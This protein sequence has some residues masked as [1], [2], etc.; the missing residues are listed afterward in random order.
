MPDAPAPV[1][2]DQEE[3]LRYGAFARR[4]A[5]AARAQ[6]LPGFDRGIAATGKPM[7]DG[8]FDPVTR[9]DRGA[10]TAIRALIESHFPDHGIHGEEY[11]VKQTGNPLC[12]VLDPIDGTR[13]YISALA[14]WGTLIA[15]CKNGRPV[16]GLMD[17]PVVN[18]CFTGFGDQALLC[19]NENERQVHVRSCPSLSQATLSTTDPYLFAPG[20]ERTAFETLRVATRLQRYG[21]D[22]T[23]YG[24]LARGS[25]DLVVET[26]LQAYDIAALIPIVEGAGGQVTNWSG[27]RAW[28]G[29][30]V[31]A[32]GDARIHE[33]ALDVLSAAAQGAAGASPAF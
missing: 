2:L 23:A 14:S 29:G 26:G 16:L 5:E 28:N 8:G 1:L 12:W 15:L 25:L 33:A 9:A 10:E 20:A 3:R 11:G 4:L 17:L 24:A 31:L 32:S 6:T 30:Q 13:A 18:E 21:L 27:G 7:A 22:S 19:K